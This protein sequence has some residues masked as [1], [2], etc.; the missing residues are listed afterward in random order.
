MNDMTDLIPQKFP[1]VMIDQLTS[2]DDHGAMSRMTVLES[3]LFVEDGYL[4]EPGL[5]E[6]IAQTAAARVGYMAMTQNNPVPLGFIGAI[7]DLVIHELP[8]TGSVL[9]TEI[10]LLNQVFDVAI[11][12]GTIR[13]EEKVLV[14]CEMKIVINPQIS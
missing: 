9:E 6:N 1:F 13:S 8:A 2:S 12:S 11:I 4:K 5:I 10:K 7:K 14:H 3:N